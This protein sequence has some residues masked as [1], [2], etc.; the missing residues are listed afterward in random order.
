VNRN[1]HSITTKYNGFFN[2]R[3]SY[4]AGLKR[5][6]QLHEDNYE[7]VL[8]IFRY[9]SKQQAAT[10]AGDMETAYQKAST[11]IRRHSMNI[12]GVEY[13]RWVDDSYYL[14]AR[15][16]YFKGDYN[17]AILTFQYIIRQFESP[18]KYRSM[19]W[20]A[21]SQ[22]RSGDYMNAQQTLERLSRDIDSGTFDAEARQLY[23]MV[24]ADMHLQQKNFQQAAPFLS[25]AA[26]LAPNKKLRTRLT[27][28]LAQTYHQNQDFRLAQQTYASVLKL[29]PDFQMAF[30]ARINMAMA[31]DPAS[32]DSN[33]IHS[34]LQGM[35]RDNRNR[36][37]RDQ[38]YYA[39][40]QF[41]MRQN[42]EAMAI[43]YYN[44]GLDNFRGNK[45]QRGILYLRLAE[46]KLRNKQYLKAADML[47]S[48]MLYLSREYPSYTEV[49]S[50][51]AIMKDL[52]GNMRRIQREDSLQRLAMMPPD[53]RNTILD[54]II[55]NIEEE[56]RLEKQRE[57]ERALMRQQMMRT[58]RNQTEGASEGGWYF[59]NPSAMAFG[60][61]EFYAKWGERELQ[62]LWR[63]SNKRIVAFGETPLSGDDE[64]ASETGGKVSRASL[65]ENIP[66]TGEKMGESRGKVATAYY[67]IGVI[68]KDKLNDP[69]SAITN[70]EKLINTFPTDP[71]RLLSAYFLYLLHQQANNIPRADYFKNMIIREFPD[72]DF[73]MILSD[74]NYWQRIAERQNRYKVLYSN[75]YSAYLI[76][77]FYTATN[78]INQ[79]LSDVTGLSRDEAARFTFLKALIFAR[80]KQNEALVNQLTYIRDNFQETEIHEPAMNLLA[81]LGTTGIMS[82]VNIPG[83]N[84]QQRLNGAS[85]HPV[86]LPPGAAVFTNNQA[87]VHFYVFVVNTHH[88]Q[89][90]VMRNEINTFNREAFADNNLNMSTLFFDQ[91]KQLITITN[92]PNAEKALEYGRMINAVLLEKEF[93]PAGYESF[94]ISVDNYP[95]FYQ[96]RK[97]DDYLAFFRFWY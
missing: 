36:E 25:R 15:S 2:A 14:I 18:L 95:V 79:G 31:F 16:Q 89:L 20:I 90:R 28:I 46:L 29:R 91:A 81:F 94:A 45:T 73:A 52:A 37:F 48:T 54:Q 68:F 69:A 87:A 34:E 30:Q 84:D 64:D 65:M 57:Q 9:G 75:A 72:T 11:A 1:F 8:S 43:E 12:R 63:I 23:Y 17:L 97:L 32:G 22:V 80:T 35:L 40:G 13:N 7:E 88:V 10:V 70:F 78:L 38:I 59:Y 56:E 74:P 42:N 44:A 41:Q 49:S 77:D 5:L 3:E 39:L 60:R 47:D 55:E 92:F 67:N 53:Q 4:K 96:E 82:Q 51:H 26:D 27:F 21:K 62:D 33:F 58:G 93:D 76:G 61:N 85:S 66:T 83:T 71:N 24:Y 19:V 6:D 50:N 86:T